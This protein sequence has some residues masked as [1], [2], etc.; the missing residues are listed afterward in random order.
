MQHLEA[1]RIIS[2]DTDS[3]HSA[4]VDRLDLAHVEEWERFHP[5]RR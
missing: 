1:I 2:A 4:G 5:R 3:D